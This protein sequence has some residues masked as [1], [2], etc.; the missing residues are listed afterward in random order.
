M[1][2]IKMTSADYIAR[3]EKYGA[4]N[5]HP[6]PVVLERGEGVHV[7]DVEGKQYYDFLSAYSA[8]NQG[9]CH[10]KI[11]EAMKEQASILTLTSRAFYNNTLGEFEE[12]VTKLF[13]YDKVLPMNTGAEAV[14]TALKLAR[15]WAYKVKNIRSSD[16]KIVVCKNNFHGRTITIISMSTDPDAYREYGPFTPGFVTIPYNDIEALERELA[17]ADVAAFLVEPIQGEAGVFVPDDGYLKK[18]AQL[19]KSH[20]VL[21][22]GDEVQTGIARTGKMLACD[23]EAVRPDILILGKAISGGTMPISCVLADD[24]IM[25]TIKAGEHGS[26]FGGNPLASKVAI[27]A[28]D[29]IKEEKL[30]DNAEAMGI[31]FREEVAKIQT[32]MITLVR[33]KGLLN[34]VIIKP[35]DGKEA[36]DV[37]VA[38]AENGMLA[39]P[40]HGDIIRFAPPLI[41]NEQQIRECVSIFEKSLKQCEG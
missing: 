35:K 6:L 29:V 17:Y 30:A 39:K 15:K 1:E 14:E 5:Y 40:T 13:G 19:C 9:H 8:V 2:S 34:A 37:C 25:L 33:G 31:I 32:D 41:I 21:F 7:W 18:V 22:I 26:T 11:V 3:E 28:L 10:P 27:A 36:W 24:E 16:A 23:H 12:Y 4:H 38:M 20:H